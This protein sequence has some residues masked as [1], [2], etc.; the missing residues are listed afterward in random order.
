MKEFDG[1]GRLKN[2]N[3]SILKINS[4]LILSL[5][6]LNLSC[7]C[8]FFKNNVLKYKRLFMLFVVVFQKQIVSFIF[9]DIWIE[10][11]EFEEFELEFKRVSIVK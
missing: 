2:Y 10:D 8:M 6:S 5:R 4:I 3:F 9:N 1:V 7:W 11:E